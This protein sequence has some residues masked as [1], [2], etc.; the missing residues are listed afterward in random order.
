MRPGTDDD[1]SML[2]RLSAVTIGAQDML[3]L[4]RSRWTRGQMACEAERF[5]P[6]VRTAGNMTRRYHGMRPPPT[7]VTAALSWDRS[8]E[9]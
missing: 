9:P 4:R 1:G 8:H 2:P 5:Q 7:P 6:T 3:V